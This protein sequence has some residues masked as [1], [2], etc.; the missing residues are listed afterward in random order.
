MSLKDMLLKLY[1]KLLRVR[2]NCL[3]IGQ[4]SFVYPNVQL[5]LRRGGKYVLDVTA[6]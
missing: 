3:F 5:L 1:T 6:K 2:Y 4:R